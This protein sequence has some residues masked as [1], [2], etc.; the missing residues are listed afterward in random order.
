MFFILP[1]EVYWRIE[2]LRGNKQSQLL[3]E[4]K[5]GL[6]WT[7]PRTPLWADGPIIAAQFSSHHFEVVPAFRCNDGTYLTAD[8][9]KGGSWRNSNP[10]EEYRLLQASDLPT[11]GKATH[12]TKMPKAWKYQCN[13]DI[14]SISLEVL[15]VVFIDQWAHRHESLFYYDWLVRDFFEFMLKYVNGSTLIPGTMERVQLGDGCLPGPFR[16][17]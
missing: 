17:P 3:Q 4:V 15:A 11:Q 14:K 10:A 6:F 5:N 13:V 8:T 9:A 1:N 2:V 12:L 7:F 16:H